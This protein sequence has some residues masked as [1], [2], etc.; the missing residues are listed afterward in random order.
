MV[1]LFS[2][3]EYPSSPFCNFLVAKPFYAVYK[4]GFAAA[5]IYDMRVGITPAWKRQLPSGIYYMIKMRFCRQAFFHLP[6]SGNN[7]PICCDPSIMQA[8]QVLH[9]R[10]GNFFMMYRICL[11]DGLDIFY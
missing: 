7:F 3:I 2:R 1:K 11:N 4:L 6:Y 5:C 8:R 10:P 9:S